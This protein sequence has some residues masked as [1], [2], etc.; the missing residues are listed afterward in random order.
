MN[1]ASAV[2]R[3]VARE[4]GSHVVGSADDGRG[5]FFQFEAALGGDEPASLGDETA[6]T[7]CTPPDH[8]RPAP[9]KPASHA[10]RAA[11]PP[12]AP[13]DKPDTVAAA[14]PTSSIGAE[15]DGSRQARR[16]TTAA[17]L[18]P[19]PLSTRTPR[20]AP[21]H[22]RRR[23]HIA[24]SPGPRPARQRSHPVPPPAHHERAGGFRDARPARGP[25]PQAGHPPSRGEGLT[26][27]APSSTRGWRTNTAPAAA[28]ASLRATDQSRIPRG[29]RTSK[30]KALR[31]RARAPHT[32][33]PRRMRVRHAPPAPRHTGA[34]PAA[35]RHALTTPSHA[36]TRHQHP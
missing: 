32:A 4:T 21:S 20:A 12:G 17:H 29:P 15:G 13:T 8:D 34:A 33:N 36:V 23:T 27:H 19:R 31:P 35:R 7:G 25:R 1:D 22:S 24:R 16:P 9:R 11:R 5:A 26:R 18:R 10:E 6:C 3:N 14:P 2:L 28:A 30:V